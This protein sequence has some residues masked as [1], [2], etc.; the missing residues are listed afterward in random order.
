MDVVMLFLKEFL[1]ILAGAISIA[2]P[3]AVLLGNQ[4]LKTYSYR[5][6]IGWELFAGVT[7]SFGMMITLLVSTQTYKAAITDPVK[8]LKSD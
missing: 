8:S 6:E 4:W 1:I 3:L 7:M 5:V 2:F